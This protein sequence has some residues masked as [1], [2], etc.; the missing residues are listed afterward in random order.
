MAAVAVLGAVNNSERVTNFD[1]IFAIDDGDDEVVD[2]G[3]DDHFEAENPLF[4]FGQNCESFGVKSWR[5]FLV[6]E[7]RTRLM[8]SGFKAVAFI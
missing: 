8:L 7:S 1:A 6:S 2:D 4:P 5:L 3:D